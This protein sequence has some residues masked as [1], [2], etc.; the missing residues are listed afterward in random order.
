MTRPLASV[1]L[2]AVAACALATLGGCD[3]FDRAL[4]GL[5]NAVGPIP[6]VLVMSDSSTYRG[7]VGE[8]LREE[9][10]APVPTLPSRQGPFKLTW[11]DPTSRLA[12]RARGMRLVVYAAP[13]DE[14]SPVGEM[15][16]GSLDPGQLAAVRAGRAE[17]FVLREDL[18][19]RGQ[20]VVFLTAATDTALAATILRHGPTMRRA[21][22]RVAREATAADIFSRHR[23]T[24][25]ETRMLDTLGVGVRVQHDFVVTHDTTL[26]AD[27][28]TG[29]VMRLRRV[30]TDTW[31][32]YF[33]FVQDGVDAIPDH[34]TVDRL[35]DDVLRQIALGSDEG[36]YVQQDE[37]RPISRDTVRI[38]A[39]PAHETRGLWY[40][41]NDL[42]GGP[43]VRYATIIDGR[44]VVF[45]GMIFAPD[46]ALDKR[47]FLRQME[48]T[49]YTLR[50]RT[51][52]A[53]DGA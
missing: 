42:M 19:A 2:L 27:G 44:L 46:R 20:V 41:T 10:A 33:L 14:A 31:R 4:T 45:Y 24:G 49:A 50:S 51:D 12:T 13:V 37:Q 23:Q 6:D 35:T 15:L 52:A 43:Y 1:V 17:G 39:R 40:M 34:E 53:G 30:L 11:I 18:W 21:F 28:R 48:A 3:R 16:R 22:A 9:L 29:R 8:A 36:S 25:L 32:D 38:A 47:E 7:I 5:P 26:V